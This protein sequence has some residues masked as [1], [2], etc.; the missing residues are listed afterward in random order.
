MESGLRTLIPCKG[1]SFL[2]QYI[3]NKP[4]KWGVKLWVLACSKTGYVWR[5][6][7][8][9]GKQ[10]NVVEHGQGYSVVMTLMKGLFFKF[11]RLFMDNFYTSVHL[12]VDLF[13]RGA[14]AVR[15]V[16]KNR[17]LLPA[18]HVHQ[19]TIK[20]INRGDII[21]RKS[22]FLACITWKDT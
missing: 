1:R 2:K 6:Y 5:F 8:Y 11:H 7:V 20:Q 15:T 3:K 4:H 17:K 18:E 13:T 10:G 21:F 19:P 12:F 14:Y 9:A 22:L 16:H